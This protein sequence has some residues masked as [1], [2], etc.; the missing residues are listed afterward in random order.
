MNKTML[1]CA[2]HYAVGHL[3]EE[4]S[5]LRYEWL[6]YNYNT[7]NCKLYMNYITYQELKREIEC[8][9][10]TFIHRDLYKG[11]YGS[12]FDIE[13]DIDNTLEPFTFMI[14][15]DRKMNVNKINIPNM[16]GNDK[17]NKPKKQLPTKY[18]LNQDAGILFWEDGTKTVVK[19]AKRD[20]QDPVKSYLWAYFQHTCGL[21]KTKANKYLRQIAD[22]YNSILE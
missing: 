16:F 18:I 17:E 20:I 21:S 19:R 1:R 3:F 2:S 14:K 9:S 5:E 15:E 8:F 22:A 11:A 10:S 7:D 6:K 4:I 13:I 12:I